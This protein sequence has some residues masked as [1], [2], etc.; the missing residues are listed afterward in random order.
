MPVA[1]DRGRKH[2][3]AGCVI[4]VDRSGAGAKSDARRVERAGGSRRITH[5]R[6]D[7]EGSNCTGVR[8]DYN[9]TRRR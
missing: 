2:V 6:A 8:R 5:A 9:E 3:G 4:E 1:R 7:V